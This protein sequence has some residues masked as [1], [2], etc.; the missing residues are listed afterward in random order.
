M[1]DWQLFGVLGAFVCV[2]RETQPHRVTVIKNVDYVVNVDYPD[3]K[4]RLDL[5]IPEG[6]TNAPVLSRSM[7]ARCGKVT[8]PRRP[9]SASGSLRRAT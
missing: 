4:D 6:V 3:G 5:Y 9:L 7:G 8:G 2:I 1:E